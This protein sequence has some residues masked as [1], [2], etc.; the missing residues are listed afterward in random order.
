MILERLGRNMRRKRV[1]CE[2]QRHQGDHD[3]PFR[4]GSTW[5][6]NRPTP[7]TAFRPIRPSEQPHA[8]QGGNLQRQIAAQADRNQGNWQKRAYSP[9][10]FDCSWI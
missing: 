1:G 3:I 9:A 5:P 7:Q 10:G 6:V 2:R 8:R 4:G